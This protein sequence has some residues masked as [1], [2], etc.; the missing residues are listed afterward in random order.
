MFQLPALTSLTDLSLQN[1][2]PG[3]AGHLTI[4]HCVGSISKTKAQTTVSHAKR[5]QSVDRFDYNICSILKMTQLTSE[6][7]IH[8]AR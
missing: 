5:K 2:V 1:H 8:S 3:N 6:I 7:Q 4:G